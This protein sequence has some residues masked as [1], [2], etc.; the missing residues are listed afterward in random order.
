[1]WSRGTLP[2]TR[3]FFAALDS[4][5]ASAC[6]RL[7]HPEIQFVDTRGN[8]V[9]GAEFCTEL[10]ARMFRCSDDLH[11]EVD[12]IAPTG[13]SALVRGRMIT[14]DPRLAG[15]V[16]WRVQVDGGLVRSVESHRQDA[17]STARFLVPDFLGRGAVAA[18][19]IA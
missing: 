17:R 11:V 6:A 3:K 9:D 2:T 18:A 12:S 14:A 5:D 16:L 4:G 8:A 10:L 15:E 7:M 19:A 1:M 13:R